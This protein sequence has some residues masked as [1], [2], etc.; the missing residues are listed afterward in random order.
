ESALK[1]PDR[2]STDPTPI[3]PAPPHAIVGNYV[4]DPILPPTNSTGCVTCSVNGTGP[5]VRVDTAPPPPP[6]PVKPQTQRLPSTVLTSKAISLP[7]PPYPPMARQIRAQGSVNVQILV[8]EQ[9][10]VVSAQAVSGNPLLTFAAKEAALRAR[11]TPTLLN[12]QP[13]K[14]QGVITYNFVLQ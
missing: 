1:P 6:T 7:Q 14:V 8:D 13:V 9:G 10:K 11:F 5:V 4:G 12:G 3:R 2:I